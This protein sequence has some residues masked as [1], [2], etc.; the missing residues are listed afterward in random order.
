MFFIFYTVFYLDMFKNILPR[1]ILA[2]IFNLVY[3]MF[4]FCVLKKRT[5][6]WANLFQNLLPI[7]IS[8]FLRPYLLAFQVI[9][10]YFQIFRCN[11]LHLTLLL[12]KPLTNSKF[13]HSWL[14]HLTC[15]WEYRYLF[16]LLAML[17]ISSITFETAFR[18]F[19]GVFSVV[20]LSFVTRQQNTITVEEY[21]W[22]I[23]HIP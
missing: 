10:Y 18:S 12:G 9:P 16:F 11:L 1:R 19:I 8:F 4:I 22:H 13:A 20:I 2:K 5:R 17:S 6:R 14:V 23:Y 15:L 7:Y 3:F 21:P